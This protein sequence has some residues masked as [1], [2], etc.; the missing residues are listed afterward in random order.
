MTPHSFDAITGYSD[1]L[2]TPPDLSI[3]TL[4]GG[5]SATEWLAF[6]G[7]YPRPFNTIRSSDFTHALEDPFSFY[8]KKVLGLESIFAPPSTALAHGTWF[9]KCLELSNAPIDGQQHAFLTAL[10]SRLESLEALCETAMIPEGETRKILEVEERD[11]KLA[12]TWFLASSAIKIPAQRLGFSATFVELL[13]AAFFHVL[14][15]EVVL[16]YRDP[17]FPGAL[18]VAQLDKLIFDRSS[19][20]LWILDAKTT[21]KIPSLRLATVHIEYQTQLYCYILRALL[22]QIIEYFNLPSSTTIGGFIHLAIQKPTI[23]FDKRVDRPYQEVHHILKSGPRKGQMEIRKEYTGEPSFDM[24]L[25]RV[26][27]W[28]SGT[29][30]Y[31]ESEEL[32]TIQPPV[33]MTYSPITTV[34]SEDGAIQFMRRTQHIYE[35]L[36]PPFDPARYLMNPDNAMKVDGPHQ[37]T[38]FYVCS[39]A[40]W[41][42]V[43]A[44]HLLTQ[45]WRES[46]D[47]ETVPEGIQS[48]LNPLPLLPIPSSPSMGSSSFGATPESN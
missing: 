7:I 21:G 41:P 32:R 10:A 18:L 20:Q 17:S 19:N 28:Y 25:K 13:S 23:R 14:G 29:G 39:P 11:A 48:C 24:Y 8:L 3:P 31:E 9:H 34:L 43:M 42:R 26:E 22:P 12:R 44:K 37:F 35:L 36:R 38:D 15:S 33:D 6:N 27:A 45:S 47:P 16:T 30:R 2:T 1:D 5:Q 46:F 4:E 40:H